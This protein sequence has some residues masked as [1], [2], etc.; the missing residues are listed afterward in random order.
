MRYSS[1]NTTFRG[2]PA[3]SHAWNSLFV[4]TKVASIF[5]SIPP[6]QRPSVPVIEHRSAVATRP[7]LSNCRIPSPAAF[8]ALSPDHATCPSL[9]SD[10]NGIYWEATIFIRSISLCRSQSSISI[11][12]KSS[13]SAVLTCPSLTI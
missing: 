8:G 4:P 12:L 6:F 3:R 10:A 11:V 9:F 7:G 5:I 13:I 2:I 1:M